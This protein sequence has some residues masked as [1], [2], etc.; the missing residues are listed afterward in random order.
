M[1]SSNFACFFFFVQLKDFYQKYG[2]TGLVFKIDA[3]D[4]K[5]R[6][7]NATEQCNLNL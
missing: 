7:K 1:I 3:T 5:K 4:G 2:V 6:F